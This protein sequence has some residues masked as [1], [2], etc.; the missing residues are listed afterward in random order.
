MVLRMVDQPQG[1][2]S[3]LPI[4]GSLFGSGALGFGDRP[5]ATQL[6]AT[7]AV[8]FGSRWLSGSDELFDRLRIEAPWV[9]ADRP[10]YD[11]IVVVPRLICTVRFSELEIDHP[12]AQIGD[13]ISAQFGTEFSSVGLNYYRSGTD[14]VTWHR[15]SVRRTARPNVVAL[16]S[17]GSAR[18]FAVR[19][20]AVTKRELA[21]GANTAP[22]ASSETPLAPGTT[23]ATTR[24]WR[25]GHGDLFVMTGRCQHD[26]EHAVPKERGVGPR[27][28][29]AYRSQRSS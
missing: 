21:S 10:M 26:W 16:V 27:I 4:Q 15:D 1:A 18:S 5:S 23:L 24:R 11:R 7:S 6:D 12:L 17:L 9:A 22:L 25:L 2:A 20:R 13:A 14:S 29:L 8:H 19:P 28:S 3:C